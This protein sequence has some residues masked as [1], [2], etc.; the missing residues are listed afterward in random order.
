MKN[1]ITFTV[2]LSSLLVTKPAVANDSY[3]ALT[4]SVRHGSE[5]KRTVA[6]ATFT[7]HKIYQSTNDRKAFIC[8]LKNLLPYNRGAGFFFTVTS[9]IAEITDRD[10][11][12]FRIALATT[13]CRLP[14]SSTPVLK[15]LKTMY[16]DLKGRVISSNPVWNAC[17]QGAPLSVDFM[18][19][20]KDIIRIRQGSVHTYRHVTCRDYHKGNVHTWK[21]AD[22]PDVDLFLDA[23]GRLLGDA[24]KGYVLKTV[25]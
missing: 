2:L 9:A 7:W 11:K 3:Y 22:D 5:V 25:K 16:I 24:P 15:P 21:F 19:S 17:T 4:R 23:R 13:D 12:D 20:N 10:P 6:A 18:K 1:M 14:Q 8:S